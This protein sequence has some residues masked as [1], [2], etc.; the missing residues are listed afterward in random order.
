MSDLNTLMQCVATQFGVKTGEA[1]KAQI[2]SVISL[3]NVDIA[4]LQAAIAQIQTLL[5]ADPGTPGF[6]IGQS[7]ITQLTDLAG[8]ITTLEGQT[9]VLESLGTLVNSIDTSLSAE[10]ARAQAAEQALAEQLG[11][12]TTSLST[13]QAQVDALPEGGACDCT[14]IATQL[15]AHGTAIANLQATDAATATQIASLQTAV[16]ALQTTVAASAASV[17]AAE[18]AATAA[19]S[20]AAAA[21]ATASAAAAAVAALDERENGRHNGHGNRL[22]VIEGKLDAIEA[23]DCTA[24]A[25]MFDAGIQSGLLGGY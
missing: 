3:G 13:L 8:R 20:A 9:S 22:N 25:A 1:I 15:A 2:N 14:A 4:A 24:L 21:Q 23:I 16:E 5:D 18:A 17:A 12:L 7:I 11:T 19:A 10:I 6:Q